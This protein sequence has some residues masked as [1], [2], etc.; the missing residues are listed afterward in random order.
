MRINISEDEMERF[1]E[2]LEFKRS[3]PELVLGLIDKIY[4]K[5]SLLYE[6]FRTIRNLLLKKIDYLYDKFFL[7]VKPRY[8]CSNVPVA[9]IDGSVVIVHGLGKKFFV[10]YGISSVLFENGVESIENPKINLSVGIETIEEKYEESPRMEAILKMMLGETKAMRSVIEKVANG[11]LFI[12]G[13]II[14]PPTVV[15]ENYIDYRVKTLMYALRRDVTLIGYVKRYK[16]N[17]FV[18]AI[19]DVVDLRASD[20]EVIPILF[21]LLRNE[22][23]VYEDEIL[24]TKPIRITENNE[25]A[26]SSHVLRTYYERFREYG[27]ASTIYS[28]YIQV[29]PNSRPAKIEFLGDNDEDALNKA[30][31]IA[32]IIKDFSVA[33]T[34]LPLPVLLAHK[35]SLIRKKVAQVI[36]REILSRLIGF[37]YEEVDLLTLNDLISFEEG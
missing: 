16:S 9:G 17:L 22:K 2:R 18:N 29:A 30:K 3:Y 7:S 35:T 21:N 27:I 36:L 20:R 34:Y 8:V 6:E 28:S 19:S 31:L 26:V 1:L 37:T 11:V 4:E 10:F 23:S 15:D 32:S 33:G 13:P 5:S 25:T 12:D 14:D 24:L